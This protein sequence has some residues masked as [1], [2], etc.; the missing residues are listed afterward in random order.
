MAKFVKYGTDIQVIPDGAVEIEDKLP[1]GV[2]TV[3]QNKNGFYL[4]RTDDFKLPDMVFGDVAKLSERIIKTFKDRR[5]S[6]GVLLSGLKGSGKTLLSKFIATELQKQKFPIILVN[7][8]YDPN[9][10]TQFISSI[11]DECMI[12]FDEFEKNYKDNEDS[13]Y[14]QQENLMTLFDGTIE[15]KKLYVLTCNDL[16]D[17]H[18]M[19]LNRP[20]RMYY[21]IKYS[22][23][24]EDVIEDF[25]EAKLNNKTH[26]SSIVKI[27]ALIGDFSFDM[28]D[29]IVEEV[30]RFDIK[31]VDAL[32]ILNIRLESYEDD[33]IVTVYRG[34]ERLKEF[35]LCYDPL[36][37]ESEELYFDESEVK[38]LK[39]KDIKREDGEG[40]YYLTL[41]ED[42]ISSVK[43]DVFTYSIGGYRVV[44]RRL[45]SKFDFAKFVERFDIYGGER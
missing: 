12:L 8:S 24:S 32:S 10:L 45:N 34:E 11:N 21:H 33:F 44:S 20:G 38:K 35:D 36:G 18:R 37:G 41:K 19:F 3:N 7:D 13:D 43:Q 42:Y 30:N 25:C 9:D 6:T 16:R 14:V 4:T 17:I 5:R 31:P 29:A 15:T 1:V 39:M 2:Y 28:L 40:D 26:I 22:G 23:L 27:G